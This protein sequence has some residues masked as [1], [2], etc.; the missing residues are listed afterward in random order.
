MIGDAEAQLTQTNFTF[1]TFG[2]R[3]L[4]ELEKSDLRK[5]TLEGKWGIFKNQLVPRLGGEKMHR[6]LKPD[7]QSAITAMSNQGLSRSYCRQAATLI[8]QIFERAIEL[9]IVEK[10]PAKGIRLK[11]EQHKAPSPLDCEQVEKVL[12][13]AY[14]VIKYSA[15]ETRYRHLIKFLLFSGLRISEA[16]GLKTSDFHEAKGT[17]RVEKQLSKGVGGEVKFQIPKTPAGFRTLPLTKEAVEAIKAQLE[18]VGQEQLQFGPI[19]QD[20]QLLFP[21][22]IGTPSNPRNVQ[23]QLDALLKRCGINHIGLHILRK[24]FL[25]NLATKGMSRQSLAKYA[26]HTS[27]MIT[28]RYYVG[29]SQNDFE[30]EFANS[31][32]PNG[33][34]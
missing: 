34:N 33:P 13:E 16:L 17:L 5:R 1:E 25:S 18:M 3:V 20:S 2:R 28:E 22:E 19:Y 23:R 12:E 21:T 11:S 10:N 26:G 31:Q 14:Q 7:I 24:T 32:K 6:L 9:N 4:A 15:H 30:D 27:P 8:G 29:V